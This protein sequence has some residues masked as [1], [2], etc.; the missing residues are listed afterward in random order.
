MCG[1]RVMDSRLT[2]LVHGVVSLTVTKRYL[3][4]DLRALTWLDLHGL[5][6]IR[7]VQRASLELAVVINGRVSNVTSQNVVAS[8][9]PILVHVEPWGT[10]LPLT[11][12]LGEF[13]SLNCLLNF[14]VSSDLSFLKFA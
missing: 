5:A 10:E 14:L 3:V 11:V 6:V 8:I 1:V 7:L 12:V 4:V 13:A 9:A 2:L